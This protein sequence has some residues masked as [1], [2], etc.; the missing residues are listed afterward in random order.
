MNNTLAAAAFLAALLPM[1]LHAETPDS[2]RR[3]PAITVESDDAVQFNLDARFDAHGMFYG[4][5]GGKS[6]KGFEGSYLNLLLSGRIGRHFAYNFRYRL[7]KDNG[8]ERKFINACDW[9]NLTYAPDDHWMLTAGKQI[10][11]VGGYEYDAAPIDVYYASDF[12]N[13]VNPYQIG[14][15]AGWHKGRHQLYAQVTNSPFSAK[16]LDNMFAYNIIWYGQWAKAWQTI[17]SANMVEYECGHYISYIALGNR[18]ALGPRLTLDVDYMNRYGGLGTP[19]FADFSLIG[20]ADVDAGR[21]WHV[22]A[23]GGYDQNT[24]Q[25]AAVEADKA[26]DRCVAPGTKRGFWGATV[27]YHPLR[28]AKNKVR[29]HASWDSSTD[30]PRCHNV[31]VGV[32]WQMNVLKIKN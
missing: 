26:I 31:L 23:K 8:E 30:R 25:S 20:R 32:R 6:R 9:L 16:A 15:N 11:L 2:V 7:N 17:W 21:G 14:I 1:S 13:H 19:F 5:G 12:W 4:A 3:S 24:A 10:V 18:F 27:E 29:L 28:T 22:I